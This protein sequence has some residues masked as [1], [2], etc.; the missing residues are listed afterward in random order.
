MSQVPRN[1]TWQPDN[2]KPYTPIPSLKTLFS[3]FQCRILKHKEG[4]YESKLLVGNQ[5]YDWYTHR[6]GWYSCFWCGKKALPF[7]LIN[8]G[9]WPIILFSKSHGGGRLKISHVIKEFTLFSY[10]AMTD[11]AVKFVSKVKIS[12]PKLQ[13]HVECTWVITFWFSCIW[14]VEPTILWCFAS[15]KIEKI[16]KI[17]ILIPIFGPFSVSP[18]NKPILTHSEKT[19]F[20]C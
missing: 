3:L 1:Q 6:Q 16:W 17:K 20:S 2:L 10:D 14:Q 5:L 4:T 15:L 7:S 12:C 8:R 11:Q 18:E 9:E 19:Y 13:K